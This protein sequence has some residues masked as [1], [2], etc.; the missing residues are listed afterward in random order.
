MI[1]L[2]VPKIAPLKSWL[3]EF[4]SSC[5]PHSKFLTSVE[6]RVSKANE[7][8]REPKELST[9]ISALYPPQNLNPANSKSLSM[10]TSN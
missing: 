4:L 3:R 10:P 6:E 9:D 1:M 2:A 7:V 8:R 5:L